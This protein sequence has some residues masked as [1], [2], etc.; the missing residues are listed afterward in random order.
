MVGLHGLHGYAGTTRL[1]YPF[2]GESVR[3]MPS[4][5][6]CTALLRR[7]KAKQAGLLGVRYGK[8]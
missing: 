6:N 5:M 7:G 2:A 8:S 1:A 4:V 3:R